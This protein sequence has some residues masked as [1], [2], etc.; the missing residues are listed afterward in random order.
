VAVSDEGARWILFNASPDIR[1]QIESFAPLQPGD[2]IRGSG[3]AAIVPIDAQV[4]N[5]IGMLMLREG[6]P[7]SVYC[8][9]IVR[10]ELTLRF[11]VF[12]I[13]EHYC[14]VRWH[15]VETDR[16]VDFAVPECPH[17]R[18]RAISV[19][20]NAP[21]YSPYRGNP[22]PG[23]TIGLRVEDAR[24]GRALFYSPACGGVTEEL[25]AVLESVDCVMIDGTFWE[26]DEM[27]GTGVPDK[28][29]RAIGHLPLVGAGGMLEVLAGLKKPRKI[30][31]PMNN[32]NPILDENSTQRRRVESLGIEVGH[33]GL[34]VRL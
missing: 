7:L 8:T 6:E 3:I 33:D 2:G 32:T 16:G 11:P 29:A 21:P 27:A 17:L 1:L 34:E 26:N 22:Q 4:H 25:R 9:E 5:T 30:L 31:T 15:V 14:G 13:L 19:R 28:E 18:L 20:S 23:H 12:K 24:T 10:E